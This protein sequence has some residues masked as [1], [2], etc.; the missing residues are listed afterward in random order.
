MIVLSEVIITY[1]AVNDLLSTPLTLQ[2]FSRCLT[3][4]RRNYYFF[5][6]FSTPC[7]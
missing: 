3:L 5:F 2:N 7:I 4:W 6:N 1:G